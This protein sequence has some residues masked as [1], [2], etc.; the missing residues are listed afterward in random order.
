[1]LPLYHMNAV[2]ALGNPSPE[3]EMIND[4]LGTFLEVI[5]NR[6]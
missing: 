3:Q 2:I 5:K 6:N 1:M 4:P